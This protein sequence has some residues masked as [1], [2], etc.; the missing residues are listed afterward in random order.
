MGAVLDQDRRCLLAQPAAQP[1][2][3]SGKGSCRTRSCGRSSGGWRGRKWGWRC[4]RGGRR[5]RARTR[6]GRECGS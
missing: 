4:R 5:S 3:A 2:T 6:R 1:A